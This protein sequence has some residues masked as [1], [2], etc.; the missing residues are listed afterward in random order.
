MEYTLLFYLL[1]LTICRERRGGTDS[2]GKFRKK[3]FFSWTHPLIRETTIDRHLAFRHDNL[4]SFV[5]AC[6]EPGHVLILS[7][8]CSRYC[9]VSTILCCI[10]CTAE[11]VMPYC[12]YL[13]YCVYYT[14]LYCT[15]LYYTL[16]YFSLLYCTVL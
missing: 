10:Y 12:M 13:L 6:V 7:E 8:Y 11:T 5:G 4:N 9:T 16:L 15:V 3:M 2:Y 14:I 1:I